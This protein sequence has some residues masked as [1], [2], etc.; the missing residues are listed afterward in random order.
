MAAER[1]ARSAARLERL[2]ASPEWRGYAARHP[3]V[4][5][6]VEGLTAALDDFMETL[7]DPEGPAAAMIVNS[8]AGHVDCVSG[9]LLARVEREAGGPP[10]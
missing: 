2:R 3:G 6:I 5:G 9:A 7:L 10:N 8:V 1:V 4:E